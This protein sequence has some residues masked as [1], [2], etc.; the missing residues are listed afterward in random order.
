[1]R[2]HNGHVISV[3]AFL[4][5]TL[6]FYA[7]LG[8][9]PLFAATAVGALIIAW[10]DRELGVLVSTG[11]II[12]FGLFLLWTVASLAWSIDPDEGISK[13]P[14]LAAM[15]VCGVIVCGAAAKLDAEGGRHLCTMLVWGVVLALAVIA[16]ERI[17]DAPVR[18]LFGREFVDQNNLLNSFNRG[19]T[20]IALMVWPATMVMLRHARSAAVV[21]IVATIAV[22]ASLQ[23]TA[24]TIGLCIGILAFAATMAAPRRL[25]QILGIVTA[26]FIMLGPWIYG[27]ALDPARLQIDAVALEKN[28]PIFPRSAYHRL[29]IW[30]F[31]SDRIME[32]PVLGWGINTSRVIPGGKKNLDQS[33]AALPL[34]PHNG[35]LQLW[36][37]LGAIGALL[38]AGI[39]VWLLNWITTRLHDRVDRAACT[40]L[41]TAGFAIFCVSYGVWQ[42]WWMAALFFVAAFAAGAG[43]QDPGTA[44]SGNV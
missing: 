10:R 6:A 21:M 43:R 16:I 36:L 15:L 4:V 12:P 32:R 35:V 31:T 19:A 23:S 38:T 17:S 3:A 20:V 26:V 7:P 42:S 34:H 44:A 14:R 8:I 11:A 28:H 25:P 18:R 24:A 39:S 29:L 5:P 33:E 9:A 40:A 41:F 27:W 37:E 13:L 1:M 30:K 22:L 2:I